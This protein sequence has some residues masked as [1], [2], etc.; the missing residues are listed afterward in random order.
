MGVS[1]P[2]SGTPLITYSK[3]NT[4]WR[5]RN[6]SKYWWRGRNRKVPTS[7]C[8]NPKGIPAQLAKGNNQAFRLPSDVNVPRALEAAEQYATIR[9]SGQL[10]LVS[11]FGT[12]PLDGRLVLQKKRLEKF[13]AQYNWADIFSAVANKNKNMF[14]DAISFFIHVT[15][16]CMDEI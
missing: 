7:Q 12:D 5:R 16:E 3:L 10:T 2:K 15:L 13:L 8:N 4:L 1:P 9:D 11:N 6:I 14:E